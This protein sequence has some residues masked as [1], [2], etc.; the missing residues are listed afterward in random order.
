M[1]V[2][3]YE[4][5]NEHMKGFSSEGRYALGGLSLPSA[6]TAEKQGLSRRSPIP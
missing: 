2:F 1:D 6:S 5:G 4:L 3:L